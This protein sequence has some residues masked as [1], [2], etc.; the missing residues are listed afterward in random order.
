[1]D[2]HRRPAVHRDPPAKPAKKPA[3]HHAHADDAPVKT[4]GA[5]VA[6]PRLAAPTGKSSDIPVKPG[7]F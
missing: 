3:G 6:A 4:H 1:M 5:R 7:F 2:V